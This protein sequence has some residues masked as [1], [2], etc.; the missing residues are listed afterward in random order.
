MIRSFS[1]RTG[2]GLRISESMGRVLEDFF[3]GS[4]AF[5][6]S[7]WFVWGEGLRVRP[8]EMNIG[9]VFVHIFINLIIL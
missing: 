8:D 3:V 9:L 1:R 4:S 5:I 6:G 7:G 2:D